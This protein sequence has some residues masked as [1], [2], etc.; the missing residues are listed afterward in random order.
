MTGGNRAAVGTELVVGDSKP[1]QLIGQFAQHPQ[2]LGAEG[3][4]DLPDVNLV[5][6]ESG[7]FERQGNCPRRRQSHDHGI[8]GV[9]R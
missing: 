4:V 7:A 3:F 6:L 8:E 2:R 5:G 9:D 1:A